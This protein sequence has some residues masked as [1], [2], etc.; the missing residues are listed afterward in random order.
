MKQPILIFLLFIATASPALSQ[1]YKQL[2]DVPTIYIETENRRSI[3]S[4]EAYIY[5][6]MVY[7]DGDEVTRGVHQ[8]QRQV[9][10]LDVVVLR[11]EILPAEVRSQAATPG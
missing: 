4:K 2:T 5:C 11:Q 9:E 7:V 3:T 8:L 1:Q 6:S 10:Q